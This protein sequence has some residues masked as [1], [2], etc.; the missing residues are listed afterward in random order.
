[1]RAIISNEPGG[2]DKLEFGTLPDPR[3]GRSELL[4][5]VKA[6][7][8]NYPDLLM[9]EDRYQ[10]KA[11]RPFI[12]GAE[13]AGVVVEAGDQAL[14]FSEGDRVMARCGT[15][16]LAEMISV[17]ASRCTLIPAAMPMETAAAMQFTYETAYHALKDR[18]GLRRDETVLVLG[19][20]G[21]VGAAAIQISK[22]FGAR[23]VALVSSEAKLAFARAQGADDGIVYGSIG[24]TEEK[25]SLSG[26]VKR[27][28]GEAGADVVVDPVGGPLAEI[29]LRSGAE[30]LRYLV[31]GFTAGIPSVPLNIPLLK[32]AEIH[33]VNWRTFALQKPEQ[34]TSN[35]RELFRHYEEG[36]IAPPVTAVF[37]LP[38]SSEALAMFARREALGK[39]VVII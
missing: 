39:I 33:G 13:I 7:G 32:S 12:P 34:N 6:C 19:A 10:V 21:G 22:M 4:V 25:R 29:A 2:P 14:G 15:G 16:G 9:I 11:E 28:V 30:G 18:A 38:R 35:R 3:P 5:A 17:D 27:L 23:V 8:L 31:L 24:A 26:A 20:A 1:M 37:P 36:V